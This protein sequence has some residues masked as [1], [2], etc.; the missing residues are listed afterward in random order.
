MTSDRGRV[1]VV[2]GGLIGTACAYYLVRDGWS[3][4]LVERDRPGQ[5]CSYGN[6]GFVCPS[7]VLP[8]AEPGAVWA[9]IKTLFRRNSPLAIRLRFAPEMWSWF[10]QFA[11][12]CNQR[13][14][15]HA[16]RVRHDL[17]QSSMR[18]YEQLF[19][20]EAIDCEWERRGLLLVFRS[21]RSLDGFGETE[22]LVRSEFGVAA[23]RYAADEVRE[24]EPALLPGLAGGWHYPGD[25]HLRPEKLMTGWRRALQARG[26]VLQAGCEFQRL[27]HRGSRAV[28]IETSTG[29]IEGDVFVIA[30]GAVTPLWNR[31]LGTRIPIQPGKGYSLTMPRPACCPRTPMIFPEHK[32][33][34]TPMQSAYR[35]GSTMEFAGYDTSLNEKRLR[36]LTRGAEVYLS[37]PH[38]EPIQQRWYGWRPMTYDGLPIL[39]RCPAAE[40]V[41]LAAGHNML[42]LSMAP[43]TGRLI[44]EWLRDAKPHIDLGPMSLARF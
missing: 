23:T 43:A 7:H 15:L 3:V 14:M 28:A 8:L 21:P 27:V 32:V 10:F 24:L 9:T 11:R 16:A 29:E 30:T 35:L 25:A 13:D 1:V 37:E 34:V 2:G 31:Q 44:A 19:E 38:T 42:G 36:L 12:R 17:L 39:D 26:V 4:T 41:L 18:L 22:R 6:C 40:N 5:G 33:A 20:Q